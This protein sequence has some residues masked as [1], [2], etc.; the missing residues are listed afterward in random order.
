VD[1]RAGWRISRR[2]EAFAALENA[3][4]E[5]LDTAKTPT[6]SIGAPRTARVGVT[7]RY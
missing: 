3:F 7:F 1:A 5:E 4:D 6:P 2:A